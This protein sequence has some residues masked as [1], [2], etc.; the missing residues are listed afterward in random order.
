MSKLLTLRRPTTISKL[1]Q[2]LPEQAESRTL[3]NI[4]QWSDTPPFGKLPDRQCPV[5]STNLSRGTLGQPIGRFAGSHGFDRQDPMLQ[6]ARVDYHLLHDKHLLKFFTPARKKDNE[7]KDVHHWH[8]VENYLNE[9][10]D[11]NEKLM[12]RIERSKNIFLDKLNRWKDALEKYHQRTKII[13]TERNCEKQQRISEGHRRDLL[14]NIRLQELL[15][16]RRRHQLILKRRLRERDDLLKQRII[17]NKRRNAELRLTRRQEHFRVHYMAYIRERNEAREMLEHWLTETEMKILERKEMYRRQ[18]TKLEE[19]MVRRKTGNLTRRYQRRSKKALMQALLHE[20]KKPTSDSTASEAKQ[21]IERAINAAYTIHAT[22]S[23]TT[24]SMM[25]IDTA[26]QFIADLQD[27]PIEPLPLDK[28]TVRYVVDRLHEQMELILQETV[29]QALKLIEQVVSRKLERIDG[30]YHF[31]SSLSYKSCDEQE[32][33]CSRRL[34]KILSRVSLGPVSILEEYETDSFSFKKCKNRPPTPVTSVTS[35]VKCTMLQTE[36][37]R[38]STTRLEMS[39]ESA[40]SQRIHS[41]DYPLIHIMYS[42]RRYL[43]N[44]LLKYRMIVQLFIEQRILTCVPDLAR[45]AVAKKVP[46]GFDKDKLLHRTATA[47]LKF[48]ESA[49]DYASAL[50]ASVE[51]LSIVAMQEI[52]K[53]LNE[54]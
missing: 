39:P 27:N 5:H 43:E 7:R 44:N 31:R 35:M 50:L 38:S 51:H 37:E 9:N 18:H 28:Q 6:I 34:R 32:T 13:T 41:E 23:H 12:V 52:Y 40:I 53:I 16:N 8:R 24:S 46:P 15:A 49:Q 42:Q 10:E 21:T 2:E 1:I 26:R 4:P 36:Q 19:E 25:I 20:Y 48:P 14:N 3:E 17:T 22:L 29:K 54:T 47:I 11:Y 33:T 45:F 30:L